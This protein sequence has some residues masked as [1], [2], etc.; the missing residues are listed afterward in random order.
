MGARTTGWVLRFG[1]TASSGYF[2]DRTTRSACTFSEKVGTSR[3]SR[4]R[5]ERCSSAAVERVVG[6]VRSRCW[7]VLA[8]S[9]G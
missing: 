1:Q 4:L 7:N 5:F 2:I 6:H 9:D 3:Q 8:L